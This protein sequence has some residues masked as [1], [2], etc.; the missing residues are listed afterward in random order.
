MIVWEL[1]LRFSGA[2]SKEYS[3]PIAALVYA[4][5][6]MYYLIWY[7]SSFGAGCSLFELPNSFFIKRRLEIREGKTAENG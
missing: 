7:L 4:F 3:H 5:M 1:L 6:K 2:C